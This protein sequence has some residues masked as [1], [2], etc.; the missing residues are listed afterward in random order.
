MVFVWFLCGM[1]VTLNLCCKL[2]WFLF[3]EAW[4][5]SSFLQRLRIWDQ[6]RLP[7]I[8][9]WATASYQN[10]PKSTNQQSNQQISQHLDLCCYVPSSPSCRAWAML[11]SQRQGGRSWPSWL[12]GFHMAWNHW[13]AVLMHG[14]FPTVL[15][16][17]SICW[18]QPQEFSNMDL[19]HNGI[20]EAGFRFTWQATSLQC[21]PK[22]MPVQL[23]LRN[24]SEAC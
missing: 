17:T 19:N 23:R 12:K 9:F 3:L 18:I 6:V 1:F 2:F 11:K 10:H 5:F 15:M 8:I 16:G 7:L 4:N 14:F 20:I 22:V 24:W 13:V 21:P